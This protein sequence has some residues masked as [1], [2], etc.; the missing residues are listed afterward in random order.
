MEAP[1][2]ALDQILVKDALSK[3][4]ETYPVLEPIFPKVYPKLKP[5]FAKSI[6]YHIPILR[7]TTLVLYTKIVKVDTPPECTVP[8]PKY[9]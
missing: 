6:P 7:I 9:I 4:Q 3:F 8:Y 2:S 5:D 1:R